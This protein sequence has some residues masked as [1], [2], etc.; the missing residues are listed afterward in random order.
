LQAENSYVI[1]MSVSKN[2][3]KLRIKFT[4]ALKNLNLNNTAK[5]TKNCDTLLRETRKDLCK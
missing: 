4:I 1:P 5:L 3:I 2:K